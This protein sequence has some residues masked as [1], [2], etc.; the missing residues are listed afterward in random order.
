VRLCS[1]V[2]T[3]FSNMNYS[4]AKG[5]S[6][7]MTV[8]LIMVAKLLNTITG[9][10]T[11][12]S[13]DRMTEQM[14]QMVA[15]V[16]TTAWGG[17]HGSLALFLDDVNYTTIIH[18]TVTLTAPLVQPPVVNPAIEDNTPQHKLLGLQADMKNLQKAFDLQG[19]SPT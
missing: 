13:M 17:L 7:H 10:P 8:N 15:P 2:V 12:K 1:A 11:T 19:P 4:S 16:K 9:Q 3:H 5:L 14:A 6:V 18:Q